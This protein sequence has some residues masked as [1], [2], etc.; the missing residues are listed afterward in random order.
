MWKYI[1]Y[2]TEFG[3]DLS[4]DSKRVTTKPFLKN[5][6]SK[7]HVSDLIYVKLHRRLK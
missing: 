4:F 2:F 5:V 7:R 1:N 3:F 6:E